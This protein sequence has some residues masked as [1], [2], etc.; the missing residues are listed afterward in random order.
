MQDDM[1]REYETYRTRLLD[2][3]KMIPESKYDMR[4]APDVRSVKEVI[5]HVA[6]NNYMLLELMGQQKTPEEL[7]PGLPSGA[8]ERARFVA[9][10]NVEL[11]KQISGKQKVLDMTERAMA[12]GGEPIKTLPSA[13]LNTAAMFFDRKSSLGGLQLRAIAHLHEHLG[14]L[15]AY[16]RMAGVTPPWSQ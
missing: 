8:V 13:K 7:F 5:L 12:A 10:K 15:I 2:L 16:A 4:P 6:L 9:R 3:A 11:E 14:Q 1:V